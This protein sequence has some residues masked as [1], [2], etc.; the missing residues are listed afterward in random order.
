MTTA[1]YNPLS[2]VLFVFINGASAVGKSTLATRLSQQL[3][4]DNIASKVIS[5]DD[6]Y[7]RGRQSL[8]TFV[9]KSDF[10]KPETLSLDIMNENIMSLS[11]GKPAEKPIFPFSEDY[12]EKTEQVQPANVI[13]IEGMFAAYYVKHNL[14]SVIDKIL[15]NVT[16]DSYLKII[17]ERKSR[18]SVERFQAEDITA[19][20][21]KKLVGPSF[22]KFTALGSAGA[23]I[24]ILHSFANKQ[25]AFSSDIKEIKAYIKDK[26]KKKEPNNNIGLSIY[27]KIFT[28][29]TVVGNSLSSFLI[30]Q[31]I[32]STIFQTKL[33]NVEENKN[34]SISDGKKDAPMANSKR[35]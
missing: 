3:I 9:D 22:F 32:L 21:E 26:I 30:P 6:Y 19:R 17:A 4:Q 23:D 12:E 16:T 5:M 31:V 25:E 35:C 27:H 2:P 24:H 14:P 33:M 10:Y 7:Y 8:K 29:M 20:R 1:F 18:D 11:Q 28:M 15:I 34:L 13:I